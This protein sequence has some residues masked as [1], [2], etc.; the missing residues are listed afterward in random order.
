MYRMNSTTLAAAILCM[1]AAAFS[2]CGG[3]STGQRDPVAPPPAVPNADVGQA[4]AAQDAALAAEQRAATQKRT[5]QA[6]SR[7]P[8]LGRN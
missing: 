3:S 8:V 1:G 2:G 4:R 6:V 7:D 5:D